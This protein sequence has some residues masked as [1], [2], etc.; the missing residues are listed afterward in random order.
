[1]FYNKSP[2]N[3]MVMPFNFMVAKCHSLPSPV[4]D[5]EVIAVSKKYQIII[6]IRKTETEH[7]VGFSFHS[8]SH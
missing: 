4:H 1:M 2:Y 8:L 5:V 3:V 6:I 7:Q